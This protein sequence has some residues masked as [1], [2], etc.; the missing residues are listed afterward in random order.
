MFG[1]NAPD[2]GH[3]DSVEKYDP[4]MGSWTTTAAKLPKPTEG[5]RATNIDDRVLIF[6]I[7]MHLVSN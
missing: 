2:L 4:I 6:G 7:G 1:G 5:L 3:L